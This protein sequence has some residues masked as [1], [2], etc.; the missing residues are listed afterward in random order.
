M[1]QR[2]QTS[3]VASKA[4]SDY[5]MADQISTVFCVLARRLRPRLAVRPRVSARTGRG[6]GGWLAPPPWSNRKA[7]RSHPQ[8]NRLPS[9]AGPNTS[10]PVGADPQFGGAAQAPRRSGARPTSRPL[11]SQPTRTAIRRPAARPTSS[12]SSTLR[13]T[14]PA[15]RLAPEGRIRVSIATHQS[16]SNIHAHWLPRSGER[17]R[18]SMRRTRRCGKTPLRRI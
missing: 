16:P 11:A 13:P 9:A 7:A 6:A 2:R 8:Q 12:P 10:R 5:P 18:R 4:I 14:P 17:N 15:N 1:V 3:S